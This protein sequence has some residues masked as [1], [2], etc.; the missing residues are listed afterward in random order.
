MV[1][2]QKR[3][4]ISISCSLPKTS[5]NI[6]TRLIASFSAVRRRCE[7]LANLTEPLAAMAIS[8]FHMWTS[9]LASIDRSG[10]HVAVISGLAVVCATVLLYIV[11]SSLSRPMPANS[12]PRPRRTSSNLVEDPRGDTGVPSMAS[13]LAEKPRKDLNVPSVRLTSAAE[14]SES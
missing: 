13:V 5:S 10:H 6:F 12:M 1:W 7:V 2:Q 14:L 3:L 9:E 11:A 8:N 4:Y